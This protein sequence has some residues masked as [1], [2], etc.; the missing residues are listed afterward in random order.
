M[1]LLLRAIHQTYAHRLLTCH[2]LA[3]LCLLSMDQTLACMSLLQSGLTP[4]HHHLSTTRDTNLR[5]DLV[6]LNL[7]VTAGPHPTGAMLE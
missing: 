4:G 1:D 6:T 5:V 2:L 7:M 3:D